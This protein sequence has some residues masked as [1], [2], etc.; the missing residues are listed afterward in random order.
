MG[1]FNVPAKRKAKPVVY[2]ITADGCWRCTSHPMFTNGYP[3]IVRDKPRKMNRVVFELFKG[4]IGAG[5][6]VCHTCDHPWCI[7]PDH[8]FLGTNAENSADMVAKHRSIRG[9]ASSTSK[10]TEADVLEIRRLLDNGHTRG[11]IAKQYNVSC[12]AIRLIHLRWNWAWL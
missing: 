7:N 6:C 8:L 10:L 11:S 9:E 2:A 3:V 1:S 4:P 12:N 5:L